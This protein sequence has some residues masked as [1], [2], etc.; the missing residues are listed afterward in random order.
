[1]KKVCVIGLG[2]IGLPTAAIIADKDIEVIGV[3]INSELIESIK[4]RDINKEEPNLK[5]LVDK[6]L[7]NGKFIPTNKIEKAD[8]FIIAVPTPI[9]YDSNSKPIPDMQFVFSAA[10]ELAKY[11]EKNNMIIIES[12]C[13]IGTTQKVSEL[14]ENN[15]KISKD[16]IDFVCC[17]ERVIPGNILQEIVYNDRIL[18]GLR[19]ESTKKCKNFYQ[20]FC[21]GQIHETTAETAELAKL[22]EN[23]YRDVNIA[24]ANEISIICEKL[25]IKTKDLIKLTNCHPRVSI[26]NPGCG[27]GGHCIAVDPNFIVSKFPEESLLIQT[28]RRVNENKKEWSL[29]KIK[30]SIKNYKVIK[31]KEP[32]I[33]CLGLSFKSNVN[34]IRNSPSLDIVN[35]LKK[36][37]FDILVCEPNLKFH[38]DLKLDTLEIT[39]S[40]S[41]ILVF[42]VGH[43]EFINLEPYILKDKYL[44]DLCGITK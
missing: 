21:K 39:L 36:E 34:D 40:E 33:G 24:F 32:V 15:S 41:D 42:L 3:D 10:K 12:T 38:K 20:Y 18:G 13:S 29:N 30:E 2:Y 19:K 6:V 44:I 31:N 37:G 9:N 16:E 27:V 4:E 11:I 14:V 17:P 7:S 35:S 25:N 5:C 26:L 23:S 1:M 8:I 28:A 22:T 43:K